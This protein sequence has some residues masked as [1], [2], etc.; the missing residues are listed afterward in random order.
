MLNAGQISDVFESRLGFHIILVVEK[1]DQTVHVKQIFIKVSPSEALLQKTSDLLDSIKNN[2]KN[3]TD[4]IAAV[5]RYSTDNQTKANDGRMGWRALYELPDKI[6]SAI[7][8]VK[9][10]SIA[11]P[12]ATATILACIG[13][14]VEK[15]NGN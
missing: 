2:S 11:L 7:D 1:K 9:A 14:R 15:R 4:F 13:R 6:K 12:F 10:D 3:K 8:S 5:K